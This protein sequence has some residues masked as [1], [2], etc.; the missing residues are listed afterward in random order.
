MTGKAS[1]F[2]VD[3][4]EVATGDRATY[5]FDAPWTDDMK[6]GFESGEFS[7]NQF[8]AYAWQRAKGVPI[9]VALRNSKRFD[10]AAPRM[11]LVQIEAAGKVL[12]ADTP[13]ENTCG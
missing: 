3:L 4:A 1:L 11:F 7:R 8:R 2:L 9:D 13:L 12:Y 10:D 6:R 5:V